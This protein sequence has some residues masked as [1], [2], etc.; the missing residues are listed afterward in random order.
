MSHRPPPPNYAGSYGR[1]QQG[2]YYQPQQQ[3]GRP[4]PPQYNPTPPG[5]YYNQRPHYQP[6]AQQ[7]PPPGA[8]PTLWYWFT[9]VDQDRS[10]AISADELSAALVNGDFTPFNMETV[11]LMLNMFDSDG[12]GTINFQEFCGLWRYIEDWKKCFR[13]FDTDGSGTIDQF[14]LFDA[15]KRFGFNVSRGFVEHAVRKFDRKEGKPGQQSGTLTFDSFIQV[16]VTV[17]TLTEAF[18][19]FDTDGDGWVN[20]SYDQFLLLSIGGRSA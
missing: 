12:D 7:G 19:R 20:L 16:C 3:Y 15:L 6:P 18:R 5:S 2:S 4:P 9:A 14:E 17:R 1:P 8:D 13:S 10:G 11:R